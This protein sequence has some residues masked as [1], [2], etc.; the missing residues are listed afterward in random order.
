MKVLI[1]S[2]NTGGGHNAAAS[3]VKDKFI[4]CGHEC[5]ITDAL[6]FISDGTSRFMSEGLQFVYRNIPDL[7][8]GGY[9]VSDLH[10]GC[11]DE[12]T[13]IYDFF[14][15][16]TGRLLRYI[17]Q[18][19]FDVVLCTHVFAAY[20][21]TIIRKHHPL[22]AIT[23]FIATDYTFSPSGEHTKLDVYFT[24]DSSLSYEFMKY[25]IKKKRLVP[26]GIP[27]DKTFFEQ[28]T[29]QEAKDR[30]GLP[31][32][33]RHAVMM[34][35]SMGCGPLK[36]MTEYLSLGIH[37]NQYLSVV[38]G[39]NNK[40]YKHLKNK[41]KDNRNIRI[42]GYVKNVSALLKSADLY[43]TKP[44]GVSISEAAIL[45]LPMVFVDAVAGCEEYNMQYF[46]QRGC[47]LTRK[48][49]MGLTYL[50]LTLLGDRE[51]LLN[52]HRNFDSVCRQDGAQII[53]DEIVKRYDSRQEESPIE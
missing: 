23:G 1:L 2:C 12:G 16:G 49:V 53:V 48:S 17:K 42:Y 36:R 31:K 19:E 46:I 10:R 24:P 45:R 7:F 3:A 29:R 41:Y 11:F 14:E 22:D 28:F 21:L 40:L 44:G 35:G 25:G 34:F 8:R 39:N 37:R 26:S 13:G 30:L 6:R 52:M 32:N 47:A 27:V 50:V 38:C 15:S 51:S 5:V 33:C 4:E 43:I 18:K 9:E 20:M